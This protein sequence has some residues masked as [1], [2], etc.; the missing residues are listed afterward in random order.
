[1]STRHCY[2]KTTNQNEPLLGYKGFI[3]LT[4]NRSMGAGG[5]VSV[6]SVAGW[7][8]D[9]QILA[10]PFINS[11][12]TAATQSHQ[13]RAGYN[14]GED[15][16]L[17]VTE[18]IAFET[19]GSCQLF[20]NPTIG[21]IVI[22]CTLWAMR[23]HHFWELQTAQQM[24]C[25]GHLRRG[26]W[27][28]FPTYLE[29]QYFPILY[30]RLPRQNKWGKATGPVRW[31]VNIALLVGGIAGSLY[32]L[33]A[34]I[35]NLF[36][37][38]SGQSGDSIFNS[39]YSELRLTVVTNCPQWIVTI[40]YYLYNSTLTEMLSAAEYNSQGLNPLLLRVT[41]P[42]KNSQQRSTY[43]FDDSITAI[44]WLVS[45]GYFFSLT[46]PYYENGNL[47][48]IAK[49][50]PVFILMVPLAAAGILVIFLSVLLIALALR[51]LKSLVP[52]AATRSDSVRAACHPPGDDACLATAAHGEV[53]WG[54][55]DFPSDWIIEHGDRTD[56]RKGHCSFTSQ[57][58]R[59]PSLG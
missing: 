9:N 12:D 6:L 7:S 42:V 59:Q 19:N 16:F 44:D 38:N 34:L 33:I 2:E 23:W 47:I 55:T 8:S 41:W 36:Y 18:C 30:K 20:Y 37:H 15:N 39:I 3:F 10:F 26:D 32:F 13:C 49:N 17:H 57:E 31:T 46:I 29:R 50:S 48:Y 5:D 45:Q 22:V 52:L 25:A 43:W 28:P 14:R 51:R 4:S 24:G 21:V 11:L 58:V 54:K 56:A 35:A 53:M 40:F 27:L 1:M